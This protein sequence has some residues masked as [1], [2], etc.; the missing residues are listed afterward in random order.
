MVKEAKKKNVKCILGYPVA[1]FL[2]ER[3]TS[4]QKYG[5]SD[6]QK[7]SGREGKLFSNYAWTPKSW[8]FDK[9][10]EV[11]VSPYLGFIPALSTLQMFESN[12][13]VRGC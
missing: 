8:S 11:G 10:Q 12:E 4:L 1:F 5:R 6:H 13:A 9:L 7:S 2:R 3:E